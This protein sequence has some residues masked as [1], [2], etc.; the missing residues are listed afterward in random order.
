MRLP[1]VL[2]LAAYAWA[3]AVAYP[4]P[5]AAPAANQT[6]AAAAAVE[7]RWGFN[8]GW[9]GLHVRIWDEHWEYSYGPKNDA[10]RE[11]KR[12]PK[13]RVEV[14]DGQQN[15]RAAK[16]EKIEAYHVILAHPDVANANPVPNR[17]P[18]GAAQEDD[19][20]LPETLCMWFTPEDMNNVV[21]SPPS[22]VVRCWLVGGGGGGREP[23]FY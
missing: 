11:G 1:T 22:V 2:S 4:A 12:L 18:A 15:Q 14:Y 13:Y 3:A 23:A 8:H 7:R 9:C 17:P 6:A 20:G 21:S 10:I 5:A 16:E 19:K